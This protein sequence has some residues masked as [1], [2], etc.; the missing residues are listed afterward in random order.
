MM[1]ATT[2]LKA[3]AAL[4]VVF[5]FV[6]SGLAQASFSV[7]MDPGTPGIQNTRLALPGDLF[8]V[9]IVLSVG[10]AGV[11]SYSVS[12]QFDT[13]ML[14]LNGVTPAANNPAL[15]GG[16]S[17]LAAPTW[18]NGQGWVH[19]FN[20]ATFGLGP[21]S[22]NF[23]VGTINFKV[24][25]TIKNGSPAITLGF[26]NTPLDAMFDNSGN[27][28][29]PVFQ[30][31]TLLVFPPRLSVLL[32]NA[33]SIRVSWRTNY[34]GFTLQQNSTLGTTNW[35]PVTNS[36]AVDGENWQVLISPL[37]HTGFYRLFQP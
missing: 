19:S 30:S 22:T 37:V 1:K 29:I 33:N 34:T 12:A 14:S 7:D 11:S 6:A 35:T 32:T 24:L 10:A 15:P 9:G 16:L 18:N 5:G 20:A 31:G 3:T 8:T 27:P 28:V 26:F 21:V 2:L 23:L 4:T 36:P 17:P 25:P 13:T